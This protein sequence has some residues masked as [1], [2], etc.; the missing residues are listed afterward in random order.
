MRRSLL[1][2]LVLLVALVG[3]S[4]AGADDDCVT[5]DTTGSGQ[6]IT[7]PGEI[8][9]RTIATIDSGLLQGTT[10]AAFVPTGL[11]DGVLSFAGDIVFTTVEE[12]DDEGGDV[13][14]LTV[15]LT[16]TLDV[17]TGDFVASGDVVSGTGEFDETTGS[18]VL[19]GVQD[20][21]DGSFTETVTGE[22]C[23]D[24]ADDDGEDEDDDGEDDDGEDDD[25]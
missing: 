2:A 25:D 8:P 13:S 7:P 14:T 5:V 11:A 4:P 23:L 21:V 15:A 3:A 16:G 20:L 17:V 22:L 9:I 24:G 18:L 12:D 6:G 19:A 10:A 1:F